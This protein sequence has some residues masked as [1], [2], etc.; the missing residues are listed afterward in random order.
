MTVLNTDNPD[1]KMAVLCQK[2][3]DTL[4]IIFKGNKKNRVMK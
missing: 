1:E 2:V 4:V 3:L